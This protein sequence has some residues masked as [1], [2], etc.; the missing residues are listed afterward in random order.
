MKVSHERSELAQGEL[1][2]DLEEEAK[3]LQ[4]RNAALEAELGG[5]RRDLRRAR[6]NPGYR[7]ANNISRALKPISRWISRAGRRHIQF[8][9]PKGPAHNGS[10][11]IPCSPAMKKTLRMVGDAVQTVFFTS[12]T[13]RNWLLHKALSHKPERQ[14]CFTPEE[15]TQ[16]IAANFFAIPEKPILRH[17]GPAAFAHQEWIVI[18]CDDPGVLWPLLKGRFWP[19]Q[20]L[21]L[22]GKNVVR[23][24]S[25]TEQGPDFVF[26]AAPP[27]AWLD[28][29]SDYL[30]RFA[31]W[32]AAHQRLAASTPGGN[33]WPKISIVTPSFNQG[34]FITDTFESVL[35]QNYPNSEYLVLDGG[36]T[37]ETRSILDRYRPRLAYSCSQKDNGQADAI[38]KGF[39][40]V[41]GEIM[42][43]LNSDDQY[44]PDALLH[45]A[46]A[47]DL[48]PEA[49]IVVGGCGLLEGDAGG[50]TR[51]HHSSLPIGKVVP[52]P[53]SQLLDLENC[54]LK[55]HFFYQPEVFWRRRIWESAGAHV[56]EDLYYCFDYDLWVRMA[57]AGAKVVHIPDLLALYRVHAE[58]KT[59][60]RDLPYLPELK[61][62]KA[63]HDPAANR[64]EP[65][66]KA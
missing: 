10:A 18:D 56:Q 42:A 8:P 13:H 59:Y 2:A 33:P 65:L 50:L 37:D 41:G 66:A 58:Q 1:I 38:N 26:Y 34:R 36:S 48:F 9:A 32:K 12:T 46:R 51:I 43:W 60:G 49:D 28:P 27:R 53:L 20:K 22:H 29:R 16:A 47:F 52:L 61:Q 54:W 30:P 39:A 4:Q 44:A 57:Q 23:E 62:V 3:S 63:R 15:L 5:L 45:V 6:R 40:R 24:F 64:H 31:P 55:G 19:H 21:L 11:P 7:V 25:P 14:L 35:G 17:T